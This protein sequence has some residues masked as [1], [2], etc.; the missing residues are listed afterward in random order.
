[1]KTLSNIACSFVVISSTAWA[2]SCKAAER[3]TMIDT[4]D[5]RPD[6]L[7]HPIWDA[8]TEYRLQYNR[9]RYWTGWIASRISPTSQEAMVWHENVQAGQYDSRNLPPRYK[10]YFAPKPWEALQTGGR[11]DPAKQQVNSKAKPA[12]DRVPAPVPVP[13][14]DVS[15]SDL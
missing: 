11:I 6:I 10:R 7:A 3:P 12:A 5:P 14:A 9:P 8:H 1:M 4:C 15:P 13:T 2:A